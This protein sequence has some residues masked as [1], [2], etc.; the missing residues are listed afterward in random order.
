MSNDLHIALFPCLS[1]NYGLL[2]HDAAA[3]QTAAIDTPDAK[4]IAAQCEARGWTLTDIWNTHWHPD[5]TGGNLAL[6]DQYDLRITGPDKIAG[7]IGGLDRGVSEGSEIMLGT[8]KV[9]VFETPGHTDEHIIYYVA[10]AH[11]GQGAAFVG[12][13]IFTM[14]CGRLFE[15]TPEQ[16]W[17]SLSKIMALPDTTALYCAHEYTLANARFALHVEPENSA[18]QAA[19]AAAQ[20]KRDQGLPTVPTSVAAERA[21]NPF[22]TAGNAVELGRRRALKDN[23]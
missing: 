10:D 2:I 22:I 15:G 20:E 3:G 17:E 7:R 9:Q 12:D 14:G 4:E 19:M 1:D 23:F 6:K 8:H 21:T 13:T 18:V 5:H 11:D 16:M